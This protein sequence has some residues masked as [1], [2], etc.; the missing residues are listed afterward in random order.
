VRLG[1]VILILAVVYFAMTSEGFRTFLFVLLGLS[2]GTL[3][4]LWDFGSDKPQTIF[5]SSSAHPAFLMHAGDSCP[6]D[7]HIWNGWCVK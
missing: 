1:T 3:W 2:L 4:Y 5:Y 7:R 6:A